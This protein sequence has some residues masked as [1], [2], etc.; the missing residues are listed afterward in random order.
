[1]F[2]LRK[3]TRD[4]TAFHIPWKP[5]HRRL[6]MLNRCAADVLRQQRLSLVAAPGLDAVRA[7]PTGT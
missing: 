4:A 5:R 2:L 1:M 3:E 7:R 6:Q